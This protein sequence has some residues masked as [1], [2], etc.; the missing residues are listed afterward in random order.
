MSNRERVI[1][2]IDGN[3][4]Y[5]NLKRMFKNRRLMD[6]NFDRLTRELTGKRKLERIYYYTAPFDR[7]KDKKTYMKQQKFFDKLRKIPNLK[8]VLCRMIKVKID[9][10]IIYQVKEDD[11]RLAVDMVEGAADDVYD[12]AI[13]ISTDGDFVPVI[14]AVNKKGKGV[15]NVGFEKQ[16]SYHLKQECDKFIR[17]N[18]EFLERCFD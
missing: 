10:K 1:V 13:L 9:G 11:I 7:T 15:E 18:K 8:L 2:F 14:Q 6:F 16:F 5:H 4:C 3:N 17:L 12:T